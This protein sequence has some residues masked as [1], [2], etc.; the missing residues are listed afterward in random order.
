[1]P[2]RG[3][4]RALAER[5]GIAGE[6]WDIRGVRHETSA[7]TDRALLSALGVTDDGTGLDPGSPEGTGAGA[8]CFALPE[9][10]RVWGASLQLYALRSERNWGIG[11]FGDLMQAITVLAEAGADVVGVNPL[12][13]LF[14]DDPEQASPYSPSSRRFLNPLYVDVDAVPEV[15]TS[16]AAQELMRSEAFRVARDAA[17]RVA[18]VDYTAVATLKL[19]VLSAAFGEFADPSRRAELDAFR[20]A[21]APQL[22]RCATF[23][24]LRE[25]HL[26]GN[27]RDW[28]VTYRDPGSNEVAAFIAAHQE[29]IDFH[30][31]LQWIAETQLDAA[32]GAARDAGMRIGLYGDLALG[33][34]AAG[35]DVWADHDA[36]AAGVEIG[37]PPD[38]LSPEGQCWGLPP[39]LPTSLIHDGAASFAA[40]LRAAMRHFGAVRLDHVM[41]L[42]RQ[43]WVPEGHPVTDGTYVSYPFTLLLDV[44][45]EQSVAERCLVVGEDLGTV[46]DDVRGA[47]SDRGVLTYKVLWFEKRWHED[48]SY[49]GPQDYPHR[50]LATPST[51]DLPTIAGFVESRDIEHWRRIGNVA[52][53]ALDAMSQAR[54]RDQDALRRMLSEH[55][56][57]E[58]VSDVR[59]VRDAIHRLLAATPSQLALVQIDDVFGEQEQTNLPGTVTEH[60]NWR[61]KLRVPLEAWAGSEELAALARCM[62]PRTATSDR[63]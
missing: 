35:A 22:E 58:D 29:R 52:P 60:P 7:A 40:V 38:D 4:L 48:G 55:A 49:I 46:T 11:D 16:A 42:R 61:R 39:V 6:Y 43:F 47:L 59:R 34:S 27:P 24:A 50:A 56:G 21:N 2:D 17:R 28:P 3:A 5:H 20:V 62:S 15:R 31:Y 18:Y 63:C 1:M 30:A 57:L 13:L 53:E 26:G 36:Y 25:S 10:T 32:A 9:G 41:G 12:H 37:A 19:A 33:A 14:P 45:A 54:A 8:H 23:C 44:L 51:H